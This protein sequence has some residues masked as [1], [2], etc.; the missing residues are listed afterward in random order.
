MLLAHTM[1]GWYTAAVI[2]EHKQV[3]GL[4]FRA[5][6]ITHAEEVA[7]ALAAADPRSR[8]IITDSRGAL[9]APGQCA[10]FQLLGCCCYSCSQVIPR[11]PDSVFVDES[12]DM[13][14]A[15]LEAVGFPRQVI[16]SVVE[17]LHRKSLV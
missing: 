6:D 1:R 7:I 5:P 13:Q 14:V 17:G 12:L 9:C 3:Q 11:H 15:R 8:V 2:H 16:V 10:L 4:T